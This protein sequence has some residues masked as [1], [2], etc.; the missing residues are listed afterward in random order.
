MKD[1]GVVDLKN[2]ER[3]RLLAGED[4]RFGVGKAVDDGDLIADVGIKG[5][6][7]I[8]VSRQL[9]FEGEPWHRNHCRD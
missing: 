8:D 9:W 1:I 3:A 6:R 5:Q 2:R 4:E 7:L